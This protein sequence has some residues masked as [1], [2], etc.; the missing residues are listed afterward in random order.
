MKKL[1]LSEEN[2]ILKEKESL[3]DKIVKV[4]FLI[5]FVGSYLILV[6]IA[7]FKLLEHIIKYG[8]LG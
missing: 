4:L 5:M 1:L 8:I 3:F 2:E 6:G 7:S